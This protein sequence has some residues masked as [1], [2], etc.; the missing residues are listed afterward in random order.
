M[1]NGDNAITRRV[2]HSR[3]RLRAPPPHSD[4]AHE[5]VE[6]ALI[7]MRIWNTNDECKPLYGVH[8]IGQSGGKIADIKVRRGPRAAATRFIMR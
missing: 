7:H 1:Y 5:G 8:L 4:A 6:E 2:W 3:I